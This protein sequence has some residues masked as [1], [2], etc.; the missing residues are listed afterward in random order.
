[1]RG[2]AL[3]TILTSNAYVLDLELDGTH[4]P[5]RFAIND[6]LNQ[7]A[8]AWRQKHPAMTGGDCDEGDGRCVEDVLVRAM[9]ARFDARHVI[10]NAAI[11]CK[12]PGH[13]FPS[14][15]LTDAVGT[16]EES[17]ALEQAAGFCYCA[18]DRN[19]VDNRTGG[20]SAASVAMDAAG[21]A[22]RLEPR[23]ARA[24][25]FGMLAGQD[26]FGVADAT[27]YF[28][29]RFAELKWPPD[30]SL[31][32]LVLGGSLD[33]SVTLEPRVAWS[34]SVEESRSHVQIRVEP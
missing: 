17:Y 28:A 20:I 33:L 30:G 5:L 11:H 23:R 22:L 19:F 7:I 9:E 25:R 12:L 15:K 31:P 13:A 16:S 21:L 4:A 2:A 32:S 8:R 14:E 34:P 27:A 3:L 10:A 29:R 18:A 6:D 24:A 1:M 26:L